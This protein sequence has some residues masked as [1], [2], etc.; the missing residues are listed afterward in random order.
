M[1]EGNDV[2]AETVQF[3]VGE[4]LTLEI[5]RDRSEKSLEGMVEELKE[6]DGGMVDRRLAGA[7]FEELQLRQRPDQVKGVLLSELEPDARLARKGL[8]PGDIIT[9]CNR[10][11]IQDLRDFQDIVS[12][13]RGSLYLEVRREGGDYVVRVD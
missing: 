11:K 6:L 4:K 8:R 10:M 3:P 13:V 5:V 12:S 7:K 1:V 2:N 9:G